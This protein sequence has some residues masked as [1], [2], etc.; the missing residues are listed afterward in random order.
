MSEL[1][2]PDIP[3]GCCCVCGHKLT[4]HIDEGD[5]W[6]CNSISSDGCQCECW[7]RKNRATE[8]ISYYDLKKRLE[9]SDDAIY[10][11]IAE[12]KSLPDAEVG[13]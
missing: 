13:E 8:G 2:V 12:L 3:N 11:L 7:L 1:D 10:K 4:S 6:R 9:E 5:G